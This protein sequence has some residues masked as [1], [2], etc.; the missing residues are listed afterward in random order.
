MIGK[1]TWGTALVL[2]P[3]ALACAAGRGDDLHAQLQ[4]DAAADGLRNVVP[5][6]FVAKA[7]GPTAADVGDADSFG[8]NLKWIGLMQGSVTFDVACTSGDPTCVTL[9]PAPAPTS[10]NFT[11]V[12]HVTLPARAANSLICQWVTPYIYYDF[13]NTTGANATARFSVNPTITVESTVLADPMLIDPSTG[14][15][16]NG[17]LTSGLTG[18]Y[19]YSHTLEP[20]ERESQRS[21]FSRVCIGG[22]LSKQA[23]MGNYGLSSAQADA[24]FRAPVTIRLNLSGT[25]SLVDSASLIYGVRFVGD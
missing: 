6:P 18:S 3:L 22:V 5:A 19:T 4:R 12:G 21:Q 20:G 10:F 25:V 23:L 13:A 15:P 7:G 14:L 17:A 9:N 16:L 2:A 24:F 11:D 8:R 1:L